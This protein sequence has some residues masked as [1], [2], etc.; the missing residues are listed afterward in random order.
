MNDDGMGI[1]ESTMAEDVDTQDE[2]PKDMQETLRHR[3]MGP[4]LTKAGQDTVDQSKVCT[5]LSTPDVSPK[6]VITIGLGNH[7]QRLQRLQIL[8]QRRTKRPSTH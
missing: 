4:S 8:Q 5:S 2:A 1:S 3:L 7:L 6:I